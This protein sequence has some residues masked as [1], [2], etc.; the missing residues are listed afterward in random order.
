MEILKYNEQTKQFITIILYDKK[1]KN[2]DADFKFKL[3]KANRVL[4]GYDDSDSKEKIFAS[5]DTW[6][7]LLE[8]HYYR[9]FFNINVKLVYQY[10]KLTES[11]KKRRV[12]KDV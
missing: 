5:T 4:K 11:W 2:V 7:K 3:I 6:F 1:I 10:M 8:D 12:I 9:H